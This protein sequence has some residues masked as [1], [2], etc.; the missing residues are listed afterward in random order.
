MRGGAFGIEVLAGHVNSY[1]REK[2][3]AEFEADTL[4]ARFSMAGGYE[5]GLKRYPRSEDEE[6]GDGSDWVPRDPYA[7]VWGWSAQSAWCPW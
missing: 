4:R 3:S 1:Y 2:E 5:R 7:N 6:D